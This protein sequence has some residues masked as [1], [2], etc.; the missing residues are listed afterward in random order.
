MVEVKSATLYIKGFD[1]GP[2]V[3]KVVV[4][5]SQEVEKVQK[6]GATCHTLKRDR[7]VT[8]IYLSDQ[9]GDRVNGKSSFVALEL[10]IYFDLEGSCSPFVGNPAVHHNEWR[11]EYVV[12]GAFNAT[13]NSQEIKL[14]FSLDCINNRICPDLEL[15]T[16]RE[17]FS[18]EYENPLTKQKETLTLQYSAYEPKHL[19][20]D[21][22]K[23]PLMIWLNGLDEGGTNI[24]IALLGNKVT[25][26]AH[27]QI[28]SHF[29][30]KGG[31]SG[32]Y[33]L[34]IQTLT[35]WMDA[36]NNVNHYGDL[37]SRYTGILMDTIKSY[38][39]HNKDVDRNRIYLGGCSNGGYMAMLLAIEFNDMWAALFTTCE[40]YADKVFQRDSNGNYVRAEGDKSLISALQTDEYYLTDEKI[41]KIKNIPLWMVSSA[42]DDTVPPRL[43]SIPSYRHILLHGLKNAWYSFFENVK[44][45]DIKD[46]EYF[47]HLSWIWL[48]NDQVTHVQDRER[49]KASKEDDVHCGLQPSNDGGGKFLAEDEKGKYENLFCWMNAQAKA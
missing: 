22:A 44:G 2:G 25:H 12:V 37:P 1:W 8:D 29:T 30:T 9:R 47:G 6:E 7:E 5:L 49:V 4:S 24:D 31:A 41:E 39:E 17:K 26:L 45:V 35:M 20:E 46:H 43:F 33:V 42:A 34:A 14:S 23:N 28:Q 11:K 21:K 27:P 13:S 18:G 48:F 10:N 40:A 16:F 15:F 32:C 19:L 38:L 3:S 36:G